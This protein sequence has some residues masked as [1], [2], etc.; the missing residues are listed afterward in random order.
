[1]ISIADTIE[2]QKTKIVLVENMGMPFNS[3]GDDFGV[4]FEGG[5]QN[6]FFSSN[7]G[8]KKGEDQIYRFILPEIILSVEGK[9]ADTYG[10]PVT[11]GVLRLIGNDGTNQKLQIRKDGTYRLKLQPNVKYVML[12]AA[13][14]YL[15]QKQ[16]LETGEAAESRIYTYDFALAPISKPVTMNNVFYEFGK[17]QL[18]ES[19]SNE[20][21]GLVKMMQDNPYITIELGAHTDMVGDSV[22]NRTLSEKRA[23][24]CVDFM[25]EHGI[26]KDRLTPAG[27]GESRPVVADKAL[28]DKYK[29]IPIDQQLDEEFILTLTQEQ[30]ELCNQIN[31]RTEFKVLKTTYKLY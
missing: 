9:V 23:Q 22:S 19:S 14:G 3:A 24:A 16:T 13:R 21:L 7:R 12:A 26:E 6:G 20:L 25:I 28:H 4:T 11:G 10:D 30:Q 5:T 17:W 29:F 1:M 15:N 18:T 8:Q 2:P 31:R 27:Y